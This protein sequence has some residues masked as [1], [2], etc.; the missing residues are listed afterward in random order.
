MILYNNI[1]LIY[2]T[3]LN[4]A[5]F[6]GPQLDCLP[7]IGCHISSHIDIMAPLWFFYHRT[8]YSHRH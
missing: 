5:E 3:L 2:K 6:K 4:W 1:I 7:K 8:T